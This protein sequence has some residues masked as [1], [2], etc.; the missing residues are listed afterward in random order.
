MPIR[1]PY[2][3]SAPPLFEVNGKGLNETESDAG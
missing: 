2:S 1:I 3:G